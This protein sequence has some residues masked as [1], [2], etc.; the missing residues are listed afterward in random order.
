[1]FHVKHRRE[2]S[3][4]GEVAIGAVL[5]GR[6]ST[7]FRCSC[8]PRASC[9]PRA[10]AACAPAASLCL[11]CE[12]PLRAS[13]LR[14]SRATPACCLVR[15]FAFRLSR[16]SVRLPCVVS[17]ASPGFSPVA[18]GSGRQRSALRLCRSCAFDP[19]CRVWLD[20]FTPVLARARSCA[21]TRSALP[22]VRASAPLDRS[23]SPQLLAVR[24]AVAASLPAGRNGG[25]ASDKR[26]TN[27]GGASG[28]PDAPP[29]CC[30]ALP[31][32]EGRCGS[33]C[34]TSSLRRARSTRRIAPSPRQRI[35][36]S[37][38]SATLARRPRRL[39]R[40]LPQRR[41]SPQTP[42]A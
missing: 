32:C 3:C 7:R 26:L 28:D 27:S 9:L 42:S 4:W 41:A 25:G 8:F 14:S 37:A 34:R 2:R 29:L 40:R 13:R 35:A 20:G 5:A 10:P 31:C 38:S 33:A 23:A 6:V 17:C 30:V 22:A 19:V 21:F 36:S 18:A 39:R 24:L 15:V 11:P 12:P 16:A 1:M